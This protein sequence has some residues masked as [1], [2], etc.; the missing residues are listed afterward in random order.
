M[1]QPN[2]MSIPDYISFTDDPYETLEK[3][4]AHFNP[5]KVA[6]LVDENTRQHCLP[7]LK[8][9]KESHVIEI[10]SG[11]IFK[12]LNTCELIWSEMTVL[13]FTRKSLLVNVGGG[14]IGDM[15][16][17]AAS[18]YKRG[19]RFVNVPTTLLAAVDANIGGKLGIDFSG[20]KNHI[21]LFRDP[22]AVII[23]DMFLKTLPKRELRSGF[24][25]VLK[26]GLI[27][28]KAYWDAVKRKDF[29][30]MN[31]K[32]VIRQ[33]AAIK[34]EVVA[35]DFTESGRR[36]ILNFGHTLGHSIE[37][38]YLNEG[39]DLLHGEAIAVG[40]ILEAFLA[41]EKGL[42]NEDE[43][44]D[45]TENISRIFGFYAIPDVSELLPIML[46]DKKNLNS[47]ISFSLLDGLGHCLYDQSVDLTLI[48]DAIKYYEEIK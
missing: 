13:G 1:D 45:I 8:P 9:G 44:L 36:K 42:L 27:R 3:T 30:D 5:D 39:K 11:E 10:H 23:S 22:D 6:Y 24:A 32:D 35:E 29:P 14:V 34:G 41:K 15:G 33:S 4:L 26:H 19:I 28:D 12:N 25:E 38:W 2:I 37:T 48:E 31:W 16:G 46:Q 17:F 43:L 47:N 7:L 18:T 21:G 20:F 40:M